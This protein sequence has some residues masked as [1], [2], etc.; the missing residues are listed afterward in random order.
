MRRRDSIPDMRTLF[1]AALALFAAGAAFAAKP[2]EVWFIDVEGGQA[3]LMVAPS[4]ES[5]LVDTG[6][7]GFNGRDTDRIMAAAKKGHVKKITYCLITHYHR[8]HVGGAPQLVN[9]IP[10]ETFL[11][12]GPNMEDSKVTREDY[13]DYQRILPKSRHVVVKPGDTIPLKGVQV[14]VVSA[15]GDVIASPLPGAGQ[16]NASCSSAH[17]KELDTSE[18]ARS[19]GIV[20]TYGNF[21]LLDLGD[22]TWN[23]ELELACPVSKIG[24]IDVYLVTHHG[25][26]QS[27]SPQMLAAIHPRVAIMNNGARKGASPSAWEIVH[28]SPGLI[29]LWQLHYAVES[30]KDH[31][32]PDPFIANLYEECQG[33]FI[34]LTANEDGSFAVYNSRNKFEKNYPAR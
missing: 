7:R 18:N 17:K 11:D 4:G 27:N 28:S 5:L 29:D 21:R 10:V 34:K 24:P 33:D 16:E 32:V 13:A 20:V 6:W 12:H 8:D 22:L 1:V 30:D 23:K 26:D 31:N 3:T 25:L 14:E 2:L 15:N 19:A 9:R